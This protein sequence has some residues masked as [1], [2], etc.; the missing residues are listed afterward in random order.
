VDD[1]G[2]TAA[3]IDTLTAL[4][5]VDPRRVYLSGFSNGGGLA[6]L[7][8][9]RYPEKIAAIGPVASMWVEP[10]GVRKRAVPILHIHAQDD[11]I[12][13]FSGA[14]SNLEEWRGFYGCLPDPDTVLVRPG[15]LGVAWSD[16]SGAADVVLVTT[17]EGGH[18]WPGGNPYVFAPT[19]AVS[20]T[21]LLWNFFE[22]HPLDAFG[23]SAAGRPAARPAGPVLHPNFPNPFNAGTQIRFRLE[24]DGPVSLMVADGRGRTVRVLVRSRLAAG[25]HAASWDGRDETGREACSGVYFYRLSA[26]NGMKTGKMLLVR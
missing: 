26:E 21:D 18:S 23:P 10:E 8:A 20:A 2:F 6:Y 22:A 12:V 25:M 11:G 3:L 4:Y 24:R 13:P 7:T 1:A 15:A 5:S 16:A 14:R 19:D 9:L 17:E